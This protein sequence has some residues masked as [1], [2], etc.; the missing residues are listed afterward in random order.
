MSNTTRPNIHTAVLS[1]AFVFLPFAVLQVTAQGGWVKQLPGI[2]TFSSPR[3][4]DLNGD[5]VGDIVFGAGRLEFEACDSAIIALNGLNGE[6]L[7]NVPAKDQIFG[8]AAL[9]DLN[10][11]YV[12]D[13]IIGGRSAELQAISGVDG[14]VIWKFNPNTPYKNNKPKWFNFYNPQLIPDQDND[15]LRDILISNG[16]DVMVEPYDPN[17]PAGSLVTISSRDGSLISVALM[18]DGKETYMSPVLCYKETSGQID[19]VFGT[20][21]ETV[22]G[23]LF[24]TKLSDVLKGDISNAIQLGASPDKGFIA[25]PVWVEI[26]G[27]NILDIVANAV[28]G[29]MLAFDG[30]SYQPIWET[31]MEN[32]EA[33]SSIAVGHF[34]PDTIPDFFVSYAQGVWPDLDWAKQFMVN[35][36]NGKIEFI[37]SLGYLQT[38]SPVAAKLN[39]D[40]M[41]EVILNINYQAIDSIYSKSFYNLLVAFDFNRKKLIAL[42]EAN[43]GHNISSTPWVGDIDKDG[44]LDIVYC[45]STN[46]Y[47]TYTF[48]GLQVNLLKTDIPVVGEIKWGTYMG[49]D[50]NGIYKKE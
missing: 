3:V 47:H 27:D 26:T 33:Y 21:G 31:H 8:S 19:V 29:R 6:L 14:K 11:D 13:I 35:G 46:Q 43:P 7:W 18:P 5:G 15:G 37:D 41:D 20:G 48:D 32:T 34:T 2:G 22:G 36:S 49:T 12:Q 40:G 28:D 45:H 10:Q 4:T 17:R 24:V 16:G 44:R 38:I 30:E 42:S 25:P 39:P 9:I 50:L 23:S 1:L